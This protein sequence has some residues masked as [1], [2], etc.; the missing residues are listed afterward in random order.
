MKKIL[1]I[2]AVFLLIA[3]F[4]PRV[5]AQTIEDVSDSHWA[6]EEINAVLK[7][8][9]MVLD[10]S[11]KFNPTRSV[12]RAHFNTMLLRALGHKPTIAVLENKFDDVPQDYW[13]YDDILKSDEIGLIYGYPDNTFRP[14]NLITKTETASI[15]SHITKEREENAD[16]L[17]QFDDAKS[18]PAWGRVQYAK[19]ID[20]NIYVNHPDENKLTPNKV[21]NRAEA[22]VLLHKLTLAFN[23]VKDKYK[24]QDRIEHLNAYENA[25]NNQVKISGQT[26]VIMSQNVIPTNFE[27][28]FTSKKKSEGTPVSL[29]VGRD[30]YTHEGTLVVPQ[31][32]R[33]DGYIDSIVRNKFFNRNAKLTLNLTQF[34][35]ANGR[36]VPCSAKVYPNDGVL[37]PTKSQTATR[38]ALYTIG[39][40][41]AGTGMGAGLGVAQEPKRH[42]KGMAIG[43][44]VGA[45]VGFVT[46]LILPG[47]PYKAKP[48]DIIL[49][50]LNNSLSITDS[51]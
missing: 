12:S 4:A 18:V 15:I 37:T 45:A 36:Q 29:V 2:L 26:K 19:T 9:I 28:K 8:G 34:T 33:F 5:C 13:G 47:L 1:S 10:D 3:V 7:M 21:L 11:G 20:M 14:D 48:D 30:L 25:P 22:A 32:S 42:G 40:V 31:N 23:A 38:L 43:A 35:S 39:G 16:A 41:A 27:T 6:S 46:G 50:I 24:A 49:L 17:D 44:P 51:L